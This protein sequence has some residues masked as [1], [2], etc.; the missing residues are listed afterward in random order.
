M[1]PADRVITDLP[2]REL[3]DE[4]GPVEAIRQRELGTEDVRALLRIHP[5]RFVV[6][7]AGRAPVWVSEAERFSFWKN[8][9]LPHLAGA[10][11]EVDLDQ[12]PNG[13]CY[14]ASEWLRPDGTF[15]VVLEV[16]H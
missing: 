5:F 1:R 4:R 2:L 8:E 7:D 13:Y 9:V 10:T 12:F 15:I 6:A 11:D 16:V 14:R 3:F